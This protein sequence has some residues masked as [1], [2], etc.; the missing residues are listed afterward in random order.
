MTLIINND[1]EQNFTLD[2]NP[3]NKN[4]HSVSILA[5]V[6]IAAEETPNVKPCVWRIAH[7]MLNLHTVLKGLETKKFCKISL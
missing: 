1:G 4:L 7:P 5:R 2:S 6:V 3:P